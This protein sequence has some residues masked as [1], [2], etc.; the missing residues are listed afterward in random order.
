MPASTGEQS[1]RR[2]TWA[3]AAATMASSLVMVA[4]MMT[5][6][7]AQLGSSFTASPA[8]CSASRRPYEHN[9]RG[10]SSKHSWRALCMKLLTWQMQRP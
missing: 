2:C 7:P 1:P 10:S 3:L 5:S 4:A 9:T 8:T 6:G